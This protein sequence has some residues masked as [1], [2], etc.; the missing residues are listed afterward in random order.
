MVRPATL[1]QKE[2][3]NEDKPECDTLIKVRTVADSLYV[4]VRKDTVLVVV[5][6]GS[7]LFDERRRKA[8]C[9]CLVVC[10]LRM[11]EVVYLCRL[12]CIEQGIF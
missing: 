8:I 12:E 6:K 1:K 11:N 4:G 2:E 3:K 5:G 9:V 10:K 7:R